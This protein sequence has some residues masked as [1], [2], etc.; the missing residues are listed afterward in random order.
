MA[1]FFPKPFL[2]RAPSLLALLV[3]PHFRHPHSSPSCV[4]HGSSPL[5]T[6]RLE[7][8]GNLAH[9]ERKNTNTDL[10]RDGCSYRPCAGDPTP[11]EPHPRRAL[12]DGF[13][14]GYFARPLVVSSTEPTF[15]WHPTT[16][17]AKLGARNRTQ[18]RLQH[19]FF[20]CGSTFETHQH[21]GEGGGGRE[22]ARGARSDASKRADGKDV[23][24]VARL[25][26]ELVG[27]GDGSWC[28]ASYRGQQRTTT[29]W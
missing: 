18:G 19:G 1:V 3:G 9:H 27:R 16:S 24:L 8:I 7:G 14:G 26:L 11:F 15:V 25:V 6:P 22:G 17:D 10:K 21:L 13:E 23:G 12:R 20:G 4:I 5:P 2:S 29:G 28:H